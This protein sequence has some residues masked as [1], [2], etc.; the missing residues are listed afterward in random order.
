[1][2][3]IGELTGSAPA[4]TFDMWWAVWPK[5][6]GNKKRCEQKF[7]K[8]SDEKKSACYLGT[9]RHI[10]ENDQWKDKQ[11]ICGPEVWL[12]GERWN[13]E[14]VRHTTK[15][16]RAT[17]QAVESQSK[18]DFV[19]AAFAQFYGEQ[20]FKKYGEQPL[21]LWRKLL[22]DVEWERL[23]RGVKLALNSG[24]DFPPSLPKFMEYCARTFG[25]QTAQKALPQS[26][27]SS[28]ETALKHLAEAQE[29]LR[30]AKNG[31]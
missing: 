3:S 7:N 28:T 25:E 16:S 24:S 6:Q 23:K 18:H 17:E 9:L 8:L 21:E 22:A 13:D 10:E 12:N 4:P 14:P 26:P 2:K 11:Y 31:N 27:K 20:W 1:M 15:A 29:I 5:K 30:K 19:W